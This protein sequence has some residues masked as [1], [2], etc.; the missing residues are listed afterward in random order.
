[1]TTSISWT[2]ETINPLV[3]Q[4]PGGKLGHFCVKLSPGCAN[5]YAATMS[6]RK[7]PSRPAGFK[8]T[9]KGAEGA[10]PV[11]L[12]SALEKIKRPGSPRRMFVCS[13]TD[14]F[15]DQW[16]PR[17][18]PF[19]EYAQA[20]DVLGACAGAVEDGHVVQILTKRPEAIPD[21]LGRVLQRDGNPRLMIGVSIESPAQLW[22]W[23]ALVEKLGHTA[24][25]LWI[26]FEPLLEEIT[27]GDLRRA[28]AS[29][30][31]DLVVLGGE[32]GPGARPSEPHWYRN[33]ITWA[34]ARSKRV[35]VWMKQFG[36]RLKVAGTDTFGEYGPGRE[37][38]TSGYYL[39]KTGS[40]AE[41]PAKWP[42]WARIRQLPEWAREDFGHC[43]MEPG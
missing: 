36:A 35:P 11:C 21:W 37:I 16:W 1:M 28:F 5:C 39:V 31:P 27:L 38:G 12:E 9:A 23:K 3:M 43:F 8:Y 6:A 4:R 30:V 20:A 7:L 32:S 34:S 42:E 25:S 10:V 41:A 17:S 15:L 40:K 18:A 33:L 29:R 2:D 26:S 22:R 24:C 13:M 19:K 14:L